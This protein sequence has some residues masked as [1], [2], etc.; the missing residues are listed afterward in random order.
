MPNRDG[1]GPRGEGSLT[2]RGLGNCSNNSNAQRMG[3]G[4]GNGRGRGFCR[5]SKEERIKF[6]EDELKI[7]KGE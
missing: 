5:Q 2:G 6:L 3:L 1:T 4:R 7:L